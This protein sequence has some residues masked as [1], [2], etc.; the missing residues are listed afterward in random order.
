MS[1]VPAT[2]G[3]TKVPTSIIHIPNSRRHS[4]IWI[5][6]SLTGRMRFFSGISNQQARQVYPQLAKTTQFRGGGTGW[7]RACWD[8]S[9]SPG[10]TEFVLWLRDSSESLN[11]C[12]INGALLYIFCANVFCAYFT[13]GIWC[14]EFLRHCI[15]GQGSS[16]RCM[17]A[18]LFL[19]GLVLHSG[20]AFN[21]RFWRGQYVYIPNAV[22][23]KFP[24]EPQ[25]FFVPKALPVDILTCVFRIAVWFPYSVRFAFKNML[26]SLKNLSQEVDATTRLLFCS[27]PGICPFYCTSMFV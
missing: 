2:S 26:V 12:F 4:H 10:N 3:N 14:R 5:V 22:S 15:S 1:Q 6:W 21:H 20:N 19:L 16:L 11:H 25:C 18:I 17:A 23:A 27:A 24:F 7:F 8:I 9:Q 13:P